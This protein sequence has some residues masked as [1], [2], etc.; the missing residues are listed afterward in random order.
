MSGFTLIE[1]TV[2]L[3]VIAIVATFST[4]SFVVWHK[5]DQIDAR[6]RSMMITLGV[7]A[8]MATFAMPV[9]RQPVAKGHRLDA[10]T[11]LYRAAQ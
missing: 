5:R 2:V 7:A 1:L 9:Y 4:S 11:A 10:V 3:A 6:A 8:I